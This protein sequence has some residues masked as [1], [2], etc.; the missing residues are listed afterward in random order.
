LGVYGVLSLG[1]STMG[2]IL[3]DSFLI[4]SPLEVSGL[5]FEHISG[6][7]IFGIFAGIATFSFRYAIL[8]GVLTIV[9]DFDHWLQFLNLEMIPRMAHSIPFGII[10]FTILLVIFGKKD[11]RIPAIALGAVFSHISF[12][13]FHTGTSKFPLF[14][15]FTTQ[16]FTLS[17]FDWILIEMLAFGIIATM[18]VIARK[19]QKISLRV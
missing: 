19:K 11:L 15:P 16:M 7:I 10:A 18:T 13:I 2:L 1:F 5:S 4:G 17:G 9:L 6:H 3:P 14:V 12:D 8:C